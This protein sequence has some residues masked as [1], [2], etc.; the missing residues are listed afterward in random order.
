MRIERAINLRRMFFGERRLADIDVCGEFG[1]PAG[2]RGRE[3]DGHNSGYQ[4]RHSE[5]SD[6]VPRAL[7]RKTS[8]WGFPELQSS[9]PIENALSRSRDL[10]CLD[11]LY[12]NKHIERHQ[13]Q[14]AASVRQNLHVPPFKTESIPRNAELAMWF[15]VMVRNEL[16]VSTLLRTSRPDCCG[17][18]R[19]HGLTALVMAYV[20]LDIFLP[21]VA[22]YVLIVGIQVIFLAFGVYLTVRLLVLGLQ[23]I[24]RSRN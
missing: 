10:R 14:N 12:H 19:A 4:S 3:G 16:L 8:E 5:V 7:H 22:H 9:N 18:V 2:H 1:V 13:L 20:V 24:G 11:E 21:A 17:G 15:F 6:S 23:R